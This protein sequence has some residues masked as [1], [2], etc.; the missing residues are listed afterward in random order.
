MYEGGYLGGRRRSGA[1]EDHERRLHVRHRMKNGAWHAAFDMH[2]AS[3]TATSDELT[4]GTRVDSSRKDVVLA[5]KNTG[6]IQVRPS[7]RLE[8]RRPDNS[9]A[10]TVRVDEF[11]ILPGATRQVRVPLPALTAGKYIVLA[12]LDFGGADIAGGQVEIQMP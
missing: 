4:A 6:G 8:I 11:P 1:A 3:H 10:G 9:V 2:V 12:I 7:G 5:F